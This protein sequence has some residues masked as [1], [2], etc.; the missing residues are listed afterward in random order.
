MFYL[1]CY[2][3]C[4][5]LDSQQGPHH[6]VASSHQFFAKSFAQVKSVH[7]LFDGKT[8][9]DNDVEHHLW[10][11]TFYSQSGRQN[12]NSKFKNRVLSL[13][14]K[15]L[16]NPPGFHTARQV[17]NNWKSLFLWENRK[18]SNNKACTYRKNLSLIIPST[19][20]KGNNSKSCTKEVCG[21]ISSTAGKNHFIN[22][23]C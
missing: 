18:G 12:S 10:D 7:I 13:L 17:Q 8:G 23:P 14:L 3:K 16:N 9:V 22:H 2:R 4:K 5:L 11:T 15:I 6:F 21:P 20:K 19:A 1:P